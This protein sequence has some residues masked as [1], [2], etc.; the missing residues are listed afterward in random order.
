M[1]VLDASAAIGYLSQSAGGSGALSNRIET[2]PELHA[3]ELFDI[4]VLSALR[5][6]ERAGM[7]E[8][9]RMEQALAA[10]TDFRVQRWR[11]AE[12][13]PGIWRQR[14]RHSIYDAAYVALA[15]L[16]DLP[17]VTADARLARAASGDVA[18]EL[19]D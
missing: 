19:F 2:M 18:V 4:E 7:M 10:F 8:G 6:L 9:H 11:H 3:P 14:H 16:L 5:G 1:I 17:L 12:L 13:V 15:G